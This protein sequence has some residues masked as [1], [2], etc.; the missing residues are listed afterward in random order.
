MTP[1]EIRQQLHEQARSSQQETIEMYEEFAAADR[2]KGDIA[3]AEYWEQ[4]AERERRRPLP[5]AA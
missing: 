3:H 2:A 4:A 5:N 1:E